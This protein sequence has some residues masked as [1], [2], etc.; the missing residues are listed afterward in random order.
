VYVLL[1]EEWTPEIR[2]RW[3]T[4]FR[5]KEQLIHRRGGIAGYGKNW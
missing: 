4:Y 5:T 1:Y 3:R 2:R